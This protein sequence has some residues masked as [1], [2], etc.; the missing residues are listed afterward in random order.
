MKRPTR[1]ALL[2]LSALLSLALAVPAL[3][4]AALPADVP[5]DAW[6]RKA[7]AH[8][9]EKRVMQPVSADAF[10]PDLPTTMGEMASALLNAASGADLPPELALEILKG[11][12]VVEDLNAKPDDPVT[13][14]Q[15]VLAVYKF[16]V[17][18]TPPGTPDPNVPPFP[19][20]I[21]D[22]DEVTEKYA[23]MTRLLLS[24]EALS[25]RDGRLA[26][27]EPA[28]RAELAHMLWGYSRLVP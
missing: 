26:P 6:Y 23:Y 15:L 1:A 11:G 13:R 8:V 3:A 21:P 17:Q 20:D 28:T 19:D 9:L 22:A 2:L 10:E 12:A 4:D 18:N 27:Q 24:T 16:V 5:E 7:V 25:L 14:E